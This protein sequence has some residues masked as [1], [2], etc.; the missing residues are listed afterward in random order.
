VAQIADPLPAGPTTNGT[1]A[2]FEKY[3]GH[4]LPTDYQQFL[5]KYNGGRPE[6]DAF[7]LDVGYGEE[8]NIVLCF[9]PMR[10]LSVGNVVVGELEGLRTWPLHCAWDDL[11]SDLETLYQTELENPLLPIGSVQAKI[12][13]KNVNAA[14]EPVRRRK[15][16]QSDRAPRPG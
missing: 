6:P 5:L 15:H 9:F 11:Y 12:A 7:F 1:I 3:I 13:K 16:T 8:E 14:A 10:D 2:A 4:Q